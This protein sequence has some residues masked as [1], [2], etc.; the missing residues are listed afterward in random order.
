MLSA[1]QAVTAEDVQ[2]VARALFDD[3]KSVTIKYLNETEKPKGAPPV[4]IKTAATIAAGPLPEDAKGAPIFTLAEEGARVAPPQ[5][6]KAISAAIPATKEKTLG[7][8]LRVIVAENGALPLISANLRFAAGAASDPADLA[9]LADMTAGLVTKGT[10]TRSATDIAQQ[11]EALGASISAGADADSSA[12]SLFTR[13]D[14]KAEAFTLFADVTRN[15]T[16]ADEELDRLRQQSLDELSVALSNP[17]QIAARVMA[18]VLF[19]ESPYGGVATERSLEALSPASAKD[20]HLKYWR[21]ENA[22]LVIAGDVAPEEGF[23]LAEEHFGGWA[24]GPNPLAAETQMAPPP[25]PSGSRVIVV[26]LPGTGQ[27]AV[28]YGLRALERTNTDYFPALVATTVLGGGYSA[29]LNN[30]IRIKRGLSYGAGAGLP[31]RRAAAPIVARTQTK[32]ESAVLVADL[33]AAELQRMGQEPVPA[34]ELAA[35]KASLIGGFG[36]DVET[37]SGLAGD[38]STFALYGLPPEKLKTY[39]AD[40]EAVSPGAVTDVSKRY[41]DPKAAS[42]VVVGDSKGYWTEVKAK[43]PMAE[44]L[45]VDKLNLDKASLK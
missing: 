28:S 34:P 2:R 6:G 31:S 30:E 33:I 4:E 17:G 21:P 36:R 3:G 27:S 12:V 14:R 45:T 42:I 11:I 24:P 15:P 20:Y 44:R 29:R 10:A 9:G 41:L 26:D 35:R 1:V 18:R 37:I 5:P 22:V 32:N 19:G 39:V 23:A 13:A 8:G 25:P 38:I 16:F 7:N 40:I 43:H